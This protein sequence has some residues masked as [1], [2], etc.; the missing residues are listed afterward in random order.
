MNRY[1]SYFR[2]DEQP[3]TEG[4]GGLP[5]DAF[6]IGIQ[7]RRDPSQLERGRAWEAVN[8]RFTDGCAAP[9]LGIRKMGWTNRSDV[10]DASLVIPFGAIHGA[11]VFSDPTT[12][13]EWIVIAADG[14]CYKLHE[15]TTSSE[16]QLPAG[17][18]LEGRVTFTQA[19]NQLFMFR[20]ET[21][22]WLLMDDL[23]AG[24]TDP[25]VTPIPAH[26]RTPNADLAIYQQNRLVVP[27]QRDLLF[28]SDILD[29]SSGPDL[30]DTQRINQG[31]ADKL[32]AVYKFND[33]TI[34]AAKEN[35]IY[36]LANFYGTNSDIATNAILDTVTNEYGCVAAKSFVQVG[37]DVWFLAHNRGIMTIRQ[38]EQNKLQGVDVP[39]S[40][41]I[42]PI[43][44]RINW[45]YADR[46]VAANWNN[47]VYFAVPIDD[48]TKKFTALAAAGG[49]PV[50]T[51]SGLIVGR[52]YFYEAGEGL[53]ETLTNG[54]QTL[55][56]SQWFTATAETA[57]I[58]IADPNVP[59]TVQP[60][61]RGYNNCVLVYDLVNKAWS[62]Y[63]TGDYGQAV[64]LCV[65]EWVKFHY[66]GDI[67]L[68]F[69]GED[70]FFN[71]YE[72]GFL[73]M[74][75]NASG[76]LTHH[77][78]QDK[79]VTRGYCGSMPGFKRFREV[80][81]AVATWWPSYTVKAN[82]DGVRES[83]DLTPTPVTR[84]RTRYHYPFNRAPYDTSNANDDARE[85]GREDYSVAMGADDEMELL[86][87]VELNLHQ[88][89]VDP[90]RVSGR[91]RYLQVTIEGGRGRTAIRGLEVEAYPGQ[92]KI[93]G[94]LA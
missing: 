28:M 16:L 4:D 73:D 90:Y 87:G 34:I 2:G 57:A 11:G 44:K 78:I 13:E 39:A 27:Y 67:R 18:V 64:S 54:S 38:T 65:R 14:R 71:L 85:E 29:C 32:A 74:T 43:I 79:L 75:G 82:T 52:D 8:K 50:H 33:S 88:E 30:I 10:D 24:F 68:G 22:D 9:R 41:D 58:T 40:Y 61:F 76:E 77:S 6:F 19:N 21:R 86:S 69:V 26:I 51:V 81:A 53:G 42:E 1:R 72:D 89:A 66:A 84:G 62:G 31:S 45:Q 91:G 5:G 25:V 47:K 55:T 63:D 46:A 20:G 3:L 60:G 83:Q 23:N 70:G 37:N 59:G 93:G 94:V 15:N 35:S 12:G 17:V 80:R 7:R 49:P 56:E 48:A 92:R 36:V